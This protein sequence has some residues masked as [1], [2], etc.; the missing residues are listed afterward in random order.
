M[1]ANE[2][3]VCQADSKFCDPKDTISDTSRLDSTSTWI[4]G[5]YY[6]SMWMVKI[7]KYNFMF[8]YIT[9]SLPCI[10]EMPNG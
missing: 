6:K 4:D 1:L 9:F 5:F 2:D 7:G 10:A 3:V 8:R